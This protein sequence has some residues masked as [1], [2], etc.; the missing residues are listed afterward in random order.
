MT[1]QELD[2]A[3]RALAGALPPGAPLPGQRELCARF[4]VS[5]FALHRSLRQL[6]REGLITVISRKGAFVREP[7]MARNVI[8]LAYLDKPAVLRIPDYGI[9]A[10]A[11]AAGREG[12]D[13]R[14][15]HMEAGDRQA[16]RDFLNVS[17]QDVHSFGMVVAGYVD[18]A[19]AGFLETIEQ[20]WVMLGDVH[21]ERTW[22]KLP[23]VTN[24]NFQGAHLAVQALLE[25]GFDHVALVNFTGSPDWSWVRECRAGAFAAL[26]SRPDVEFLL[27]STPGLSRPERLLREV[28]EWAGRVKPDNLGMVCR[29]YYSLH[30]GAALRHVL[31]GGCR[32]G[33]TVF[34][35]DLPGSDIPGVRKI[36]CAVERLA[37]AALR[38]LAAVRRG[39]DTPGRLRLPY[40]VVPNEALDAV[41]AR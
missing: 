28:E 39:A 23:V 12:M 8:R 30:M 38:R 34:D 2:D 32:V 17:E 15:T 36:G 1:K 37:E 13:L 27:P 19:T 22:H 11:S 24:D 6:A 21:S 33:I 41:A 16:L 14:V 29:C 3:L 26:E 10:F 9:S 35:V 40:E 4:R 25:D 20:P 7:V 31:P 5:T 18:E